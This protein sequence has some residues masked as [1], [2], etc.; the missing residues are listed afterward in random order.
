[1]L[2]WLGGGGK[3]RLPVGK[4]IIHQ[5]FN[6]LAFSYSQDWDVTDKGWIN[7]CRVEWIREGGTACSSN[8]GCAD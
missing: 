8:S 4:E 3:P 2:W 5:H 1:M 6:D 7:Y